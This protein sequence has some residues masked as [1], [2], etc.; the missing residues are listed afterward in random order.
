MC[1]S[2]FIVILSLSVRHS[3]TSR[4]KR[5]YEKYR[6]NKRAIILRLLLLTIIHTGNQLILAINDSQ[7]YKIIYR[8]RQVLISRLI[9]FTQKSKRNNILLLRHNLYERQLFL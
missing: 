4:K 6:E 3:I 1:S 7:I 8:S 2:H 9:Y 5:D